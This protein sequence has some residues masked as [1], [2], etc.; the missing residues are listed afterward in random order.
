MRLTFQG[1]IGLEF[2]PQNFQ[3]VPLSLEIVWIGERQWEGLN[4]QVFN[5]E[6]DVRLSFYCRDFQ[7]AILGTDQTEPSAV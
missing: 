7:V 3:P 5:T 2:Q 1:T 4:Y 6:Q